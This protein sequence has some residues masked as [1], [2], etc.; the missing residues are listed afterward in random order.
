MLGLL[1]IWTGPCPAE[2]PAKPA[3]NSSQDGMVW[4]V[5]GG[6]APLFLAGS[7]HVLRPTDYPLPQS[8]EM[9]WKEAQH[10]VME[11]PA[12]E[13]KKPET[14]ALTM[15]L[16]FLKDEKLHDRL[17][18]ET[19]KKVRLWCGK[20]GYPEA[21]METMKPWMA[22]LCIVF[23][24]FE[25]QGYKND[26]GLEHHFSDRLEKSGKTSEGLET[27]EQQLQLFDSIPAALQEEML[28]LTL[29]Q[30]PTMEQ[31]LLN[32]IT[33]WRS[34]D[35]EN[36]DKLMSRSFEGFPDLK[37]QML[38]DR[39]AAWIPRLEAL[40]QGDRATMVL[41][42]CAHLCGSGS[43]VELLLEKGYQ[44]VPLKAPA[45]VPAPAPVKKAA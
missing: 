34:A 35:T 17:T 9:A 15:K 36:V 39:N 20:S 6:K 26:L 5:S 32:L 23:S 7:V 3:G 14:L 40:L 25:K 2:T 19:W 22:S 30:V 28:K 29:K 41:V 31:D 45:A 8:Y 16:A 24:F 4:R 21:A 13:A 18:A 38:V 37:K 10:L 12:G 11:L 33:A 43:V 42:G 1:A 27:M 44:C